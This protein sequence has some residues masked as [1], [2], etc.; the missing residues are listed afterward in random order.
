M[1]VY[2][3]KPGVTSSAV[4][5]STSVQQ[6]T[7]TTDS[8]LQVSTKRQFHT[9]AALEVID[10]EKKGKNN[11]SITASG[12]CVIYRSC[13]RSLVFNAYA[14]ACAEATPELADAPHREASAGMQLVSVGFVARSAPCRCKATFIKV[15]RG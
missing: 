8:V 10:A 4:H 7:T 15:R 13:K 9:A 3:R 1:A 12:R 6:V 14:R 5:E 2:S 11:T